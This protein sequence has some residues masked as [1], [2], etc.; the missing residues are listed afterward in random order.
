MPDLPSKSTFRNSLDHPSHSLYLDKYLSGDRS[1][2]TILDLAAHFINSNQSQSAVVLLSSSNEVLSNAKGRFLLGR[3]YLSLLE[4]ALAV[5]HLHKSLSLAPNNSATSHA[6]ALAYLELFQTERSIEILQTILVD[7]PHNAEVH[8]T[9]AVA[10]KYLGLFDKARSH[11]DLATANNPVLYSA[12]RNRSL[13]TDYNDDFDHFKQIKSLYESK[14]SS[15][16]EVAVQ[17]GFAYSRALEQR[18]DYA[19]ASEVLFKA[20]NSHLA[21]ISPFN[22]AVEQLQYMRLLRSDT[23]SAHVRPNLQITPGHSKP[24]FIIGMP[25]S[26]TTLLESILAKQ[27]SIASCDELTFLERSIYQYCSTSLPGQLSITESNLDSVRSHY[28]HL[29]YQSRPSLFGTCEFHVDKMPCNFRFVNIISKAFPGA[30]IIYSTRSPMD[31][32][33]SMYREFFSSGLEYSYS[34]ND[35]LTF[36]LLQHKLMLKWLERYP[37]MIFTCNY[38]SLVTD[39]SRI[40]ADL[41]DFLGL[42]YTD[43]MLQTDQSSH[44]VRTAS[45]VTSRQAISS[46]SVGSWRRFEPLLK[47]LVPRLEKEGF[48]VL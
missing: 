38:E 13:I 8:N 24:I 41:C 39:P 33:L 22:G 31:N 15:D 35:S 18:R 6:L 29:L 43:N 17:I 40:V 9:I 30:R 45:S 26:G 20:N 2:G 44:S 16:T 21:Q 12:Y 42:A 27:D 48:N 4:P 11:F 19:L 34:L 3:S 5:T 47:S 25:R 23:L 10:Y 1:V 37:S 28:Y 7:N 14:S 46:K 32:I 36:F